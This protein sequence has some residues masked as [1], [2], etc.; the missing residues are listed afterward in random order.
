M[1]ECNVDNH[2]VRT[3]AQRL[4]QHLHGFCVKVA[5]GKIEGV[6]LHALKHVVV[7]VHDAG[8]EI[9]VA[10]RP[11]EQFLDA[12]ILGV[13]KPQTNCQIFEVFWTNILWHQFYGAEY[14]VA[15]Y[16]CRVSSQAEAPFAEVQHIAIR[17]HSLHL[18]DDVSR[19]RFILILVPPASKLVV[20][21]S[22]SEQVS[23]GPLVLRVGIHYL[24]PYL[25]LSRIPFR[26]VTVGDERFYG[27]CLLCSD[28]QVAHQ[29]QHHNDCLSHFC[30]YLL[31]YT[32][33][34]ALS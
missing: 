29:R 19:F 23:P 11:G 20:I 3:F 26:L 21:T 8:G 33:S 12:R 31:C 7:E 13:V 17:Q 15:P 14:V 2:Y 30:L 1:K 9:L 18:T 27:F 6:G 5:V 28:G 10:V 4:L 16:C 25:S 24:L 34:E 22:S 32:I